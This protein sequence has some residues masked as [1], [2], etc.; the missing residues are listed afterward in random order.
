MGLV[1]SHSQPSPPAKHIL[2]E[3]QWGGLYNTR[4]SASVRTATWKSKS[5]PRLVLCVKE[6]KLETDQYKT[7][8]KK[9]SD[10]IF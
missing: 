1:P 8:I 5:K 3:L 10:F 9:S 2:Y 6:D 7:N 4:S